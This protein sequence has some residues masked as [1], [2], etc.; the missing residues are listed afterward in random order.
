MRKL[1]LLAVAM[2][3]VSTQALAVTSITNT[4]HDLSSS[5]TATIKSSDYDEICVFCH[6]PHSSL[7]QQN[8][9]LWNR[10]G[11]DTITISAYYNSATLDTASHTAAVSTKI[12][13]S[14]VKLCLSCHDGSSLTNSLQNPS[15]LA[16]GS[17]PSGLTNI[18]SPANLGD[19]LHDDH[20]IGMVYNTIVTTTP[21]EWHASPSGITFYD[22]GVMWCSSCHDVHDN[23]FAPFLA[24]DNTGSGLCLKCHNK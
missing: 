2:T 1:L 10:S 14:D 6:T 7:D 13:N 12:A 22:G 9:P 3:L 19:D 18:T 8:A 4:K 20:P 16:G 21:D 24:T 5:S 17:Q 23:E 15:N 11:T